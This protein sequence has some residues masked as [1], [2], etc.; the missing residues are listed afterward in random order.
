[1]MKRKVFG[2]GRGL[3]L[4]CNLGIRL[5]EPRK[6]TKTLSPESWFPG[7]D[8]NPGPPECEAGMLTT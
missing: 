6:T 3:I 7:Q 8:L 2:S 5:E 1:M 4:R